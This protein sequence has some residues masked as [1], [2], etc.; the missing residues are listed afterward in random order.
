MRLDENYYPVYPAQGDYYYSQRNYEEAEWFYQRALTI[1]DDP[2]A[3]SGLGNALYY[4]GRTGEAFD[5][6]LVAIEKLE[7]LGQDASVIR[8][9]VSEVDFRTS[10]P[11]TPQI[12]ELTVTAFP[13]SELSNPLIPPTLILPTIEIM[14][15]VVSTNTPTKL[16]TATSTPFPTS[17]LA[18]PTP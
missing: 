15:P 3:Y 10:A 8:S 13:E 18:T 9:I 1:A 7:V 5:N 6:Y 12:I 4:Q 2:F 14:L 11:K 17:V 16:I